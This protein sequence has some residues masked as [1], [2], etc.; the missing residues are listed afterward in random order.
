MM[1]IVRHYSILGVINS[2]TNCGYAIEFCIH[3]V[4]RIK[5]IIQIPFHFKMSTVDWRQK[6]CALLLWLL[7]NKVDELSGVVEMTNLL[8]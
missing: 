1:V 4:F 6:S 8:K 3:E 5:R 2:P 7:R